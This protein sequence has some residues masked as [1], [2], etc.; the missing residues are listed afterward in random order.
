[1]FKVEIIHGSGMIE[2]TTAYAVT[3]DGDIVTVHNVVNDVVIQY[4]TD[5]LMVVKVDGEAVYFD[6]EY[7]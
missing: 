3:V 5:D 7:E 4:D 1:M 6:G 2:M